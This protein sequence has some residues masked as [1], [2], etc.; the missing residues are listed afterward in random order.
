MAA[1]ALLVPGAVSAQE[2]DPALTVSFNDTVRAIAVQPD[3][4]IVVGGQFGIVNG[5]SRGRLARLTSGGALGAAFP[6]S[7]DQAVLALA[8]Q[9]DGRIVIG[10]RFGTMG[11]SAHRRVA[12]LL[13]D[14]TL[15]TSFVSEID[16]GVTAEVSQLAVQP[17]GRIVI[18]GRFNTISGQARDRIARLNANGSLDT[19]F[20][21]TTTSTVAAIT[22]AA[23]GGVLIAGSFSDIT[24]QCPSTCVL[25]LQANGAFDP[26]FVATRVTGLVRHLSV[27]AD[28]R[29]LVGGNFGAL[30]AHDTSFVGR[31]LASGGADTSFA[32]TELRFSNIERI[33]ELAGGQVL[34]GG[35]MRWGTAGFSDDRVARLTSTGIR[36]TS[37]D[38]PVFNSLITSLVLQADH[39]ILVGGLF[40]SVDGV[41]RNH[42]ARFI[43]PRPDPVYANGFE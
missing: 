37:F 29:V 16:N 27:Q 28:G 41:P 33:V 32:N 38:E 25:R 14:G 40:T 10:G 21:P 23:N 6:A 12:R 13:A 3:G 43:G 18:I 19:G 5:Q 36:D 24:P 1:I 4:T 39:S 34:I 26:S 20:N 2:L 7:P 8:V 35:Q 9:T 42:L 30:G 31:L 17:D 11:A 22:L 15:D